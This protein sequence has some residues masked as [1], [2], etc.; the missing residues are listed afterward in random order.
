MLFHKGS[1]PATLRA[2][3][4]L[5]LISFSLSASGA[6]KRVSLEK[7]RWDGKNRYLDVSLLCVGDEEPRL[8]RRPVRAS[9]KW[10]SVD[11]GSMCHRSKYTLARAVCKIDAP[12][13][14]KLAGRQQETTTKAETP[15]EVAVTGVENNTFEDKRTE[16]LKEQMLI[17]QQRIQI[18]QRRLKLVAEELAL[19][20]SLNLAAN[21]VN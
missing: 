2:L 20:K 21:S 1:F 16:L 10:C 7:T 4:A 12:R 9:G 8:I 11:V 13:F 3:V 19:R 17:E 14:A 6:V 18:E 5:F 15:A